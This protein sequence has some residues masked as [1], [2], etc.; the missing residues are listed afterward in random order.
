MTMVA[1]A[2][3]QNYGIIPCPK[4]EGK[5]GSKLK[6]MRSQHRPPGASGVDT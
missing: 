4:G 2:L 5:R 6:V 3:V 1:E